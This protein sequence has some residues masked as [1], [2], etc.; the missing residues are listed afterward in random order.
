MLLVVT[1][2]AAMAIFLEPKIP[3]DV[4]YHSFADNR[5][6]GFIQNWQNVLSNIAFLYV[7]GEGLREIFKRYRHDSKSFG[8]K[9]GWF[10]LFTGIFLT[11]LGSGYYHWGP[12]NKTLLWDRLP[13]SIGFTAFFATIIG[14][15][16]GR[17]HYQLLF[18]PLVGSGVASVL[19]WYTTEMHG[20]GDLRPYILVQFFPLLIIPLIML[21]FDPKYSHGR[22]IIFALISYA[23]AKILEYFD[24]GIFN[25][26]HSIVSGHAL[27][28]LMAALGCWFLLKMFRNRS[29]HLS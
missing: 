28:H 17:R 10:F 11:G 22:F 20:A 29:L 12:T 7:G 19:Y 8:E 6:F 5:Q 16:L 3:Q 26:S 15:R 1:G 24:H 2:I 25:L 14:E 21:T 23:G 27:K 4:A 18:W 9:A 13:M